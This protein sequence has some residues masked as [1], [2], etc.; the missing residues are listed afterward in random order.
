MVVATDNVGN[1]HVVV[2]HDDAEVVG[3]RAVGAGNNQVVECFVGNGDF[4]FD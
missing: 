2:V 1:A 4:A 3:R